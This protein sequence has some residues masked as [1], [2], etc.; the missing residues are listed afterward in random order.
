MNALVVY[1]L[2]L[3][4]SLSSTKKVEDREKKIERADRCKSYYF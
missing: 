2:I 1:R 4:I 3:H